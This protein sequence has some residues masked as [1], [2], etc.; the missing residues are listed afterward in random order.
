MWKPV[1]TSVM[2]L[3]LMWFVPEASA[4]ETEKPAA[5]NLQDYL[6]LSDAQRKTL[7][8]LQARMRVKARASVQELESKQKAL[9]TQLASG[10]VDPLTVGKLYIS[11]EL[12]KGKA[13]STSEELRSEA[14]AQLTVEQRAKLSKLEEAQRMQPLVRE[15]VGLFLL[16][17]PSE[18][19]TGTGPL[20]M[21]Q[22]PRR[23]GGGGRM[24]QSQQPK[25]SI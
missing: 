9:R 15:A 2:S 16:P 21:F 19:L 24:M 3:G 5:T 25:T 6:S 10:D 18:I 12:A 8:E 7:G 13:E 14:L 20:G 11:L 23:G 4:P 17:P 22:A 1:L